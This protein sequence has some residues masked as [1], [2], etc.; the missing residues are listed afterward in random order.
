MKSQY[1]LKAIITFLLSLT[2]LSNCSKSSS[3][4]R[5]TTATLA[6]KESCYT[7]KG[8]NYTS[9]KLPDGNT[10]EVLRLEFIDITGLNFNI[11]LSSRSFNNPGKF[12]QEFTT[13]VN[14]FDDY[15]YPTFTNSV[16]VNKPG[17]FIFT[18]FD[19]VNRKASGTFDFN[20]VINTNQ[21]NVDRNQAGEFTDV[22]F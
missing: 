21:G 11:E 6:D 19:R 5:N 12:T 20:Y 2:I 18:K 17:S 4:D 1:K 7:G 8:V 3:C 9:T 14:Y 10:L 13:G 16:V 22:S 15:A